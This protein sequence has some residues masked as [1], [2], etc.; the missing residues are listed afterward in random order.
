MRASIQLGTFSGV[1]KPTM[2]TIV[3]AVLYLRLGWLVG[4]GGLFGALGVILLSLLISAATALSVASIATNIRVRVG[5]PFSIISQSLGL[6]VG[7]SV[8]LPFYLAQAVSIAFYLFAFAE[9]WMLVFPEHNEL[10][11]LL[12]A[13]TFAF[14]IAYGSATL[15]RRAQTVIFSVQ[16]LSLVSIFAGSFDIFGHTGFQADPEA[17]GGFE[18]GNFWELMAIFFPAVT[19]VLSGVAFASRLKNPRLSI[20]RG[21]LWAMVVTFIV[22]VGSAM[23]LAFMASP[24]VLRANTSVITENALVPPL[25]VTGLLAATFAATMLTMIT[26]PNLLAAITEQGVVPGAG[27]LAR[28]DTHGEARNAK[29]V[30]AGVSLMAIVVGYTGGGLNAVAP[31]MTMFFLLTYAVINAVMLLE[32]SLDLV[33]FRPLFRVPNIVPLTGLLGC[34]FVMLLINAIFSFVAIT[35]SIAFYVYLS[36]RHLVNPWGDVRSGLFVIL[37]E[38]AAKRVTVMPGSQER[39]WKPLLLV[40]IQRTE[41]LLGAYRFL[42]AFTYPRGSVHVLALHNEGCRELVARSR[43]TVKAFLH[44]G[45]FSRVAFLETEDFAEGLEL[46]IDVMHSSFFKPNAIFMVVRDASDDEGVNVILDRAKRNETGAILYAQHH[47]AGLGREQIINVWIRDQSPT[48]EVGLRL[49]RLDL[50]LLLAYQVARNWNGTINL[51]MIVESEENRQAG[52]KFLEKVIELGRMPVATRAMVRCGEFNEQMQHMPH[53][54]LNIFGIGDRAN[55]HLIHRMVLQTQ[56]S[57]IFVLDSG[58]ESAL[59]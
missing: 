12:G 44:D 39:A 9:G 42:H 59:A 15:V 18:D 20:P 25:V 46:S 6:E 7:A 55:V 14:A 5:G 1:F 48:W 13:Y 45:I 35:V 23:W 33:S 16:V 51:N 57:C 43:E 56:A 58:H 3:G 26:A 54:D 52:V 2:L 24:D 38:W 31:L 37:A 10:L 4:N 17:L 32:Q 8:G 50:S 36:R 29:F 27:V 28:K 49:S 22:Y 34:L 53:A 40:P 19:G 11:V 41:E 30:T 47:D 21:M